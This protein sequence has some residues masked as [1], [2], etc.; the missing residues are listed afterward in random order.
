MFEVSPVFYYVIAGYFLMTLVIGYIAGRGNKTSEDHLVAGRSIGPVI[1]GAALAATQLSA[2]TFVGTVGVLYLTGASY[3]WYWPGM[4]AGWLVS[5]IWVAPKFQ[6]F[7]GVTVPDYIEKRYN[8][9]V[10]KVIA[11]ALIVV[12]YTVYL[13]AQYVAG[14]ILMETIFGLPKIWGAIITIGIT[15]LYTM[16]GGMKATTYS[17]FIQAIIMAGCFFAAVPILYSQAGGFDY[18]GRFITELQPTLTGWH[19]Q[20][21]DILGFAL[22]FGLS[23]A[24]APYELARMY[25]MKSQRTVRLAIGFSF[26]FQAVIAIAICLV[27]FAMRSLYPIMNNADAASSIMAVNVLPPFIGALIVVA[28]LAAIMSTVSGVMIVSASAISHDI[29]GI[30][31]PNATDKQKMTINKIATVVLSIIPLIFAIK[32]FDMVQF[33]VI[34]QS[35]M[36]ASFFFATVVIGLNWK[37][38]TGTAA[39]ISMLGGVATVLI[40]YLMQ[41]PF[42]LNEV[43]PGVL[44]STVLLI[45]CSYFTKPVPEESLKPFFGK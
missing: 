37:R 18:V 7:K 13:V 39:L 16:K 14:G 33:I 40:W 45:V 6:Q 44:V 34:V 30:L 15:M 28:I 20:F 36:V 41:K 22:A 35:S 17:D 26:I 29:Y 8:S 19:W 31:K 10:A 5:A 4:F 9:K 23:V 24:I 43:I 38:A 21:K 3:M 1:G 32:P 2:G 11:A 12:A 25:T 42:G 27:G